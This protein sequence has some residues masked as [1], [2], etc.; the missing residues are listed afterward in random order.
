MR[1]IVF[2]APLS[3]I[4]MN[5]G[6]SFK[7]LIILGV[8]VLAIVLFYRWYRKFKFPRT[9]CISLVTG[10]VKSGKTTFAVGMAIAE[11]KRVHRSWKIRTFFQKI[12][13]KPL[14]EE[15]LLYSNIPLA[16]PYVPVTQ[17]I[18]MRQVRPRY[19]SV[20][21][22]NEASL[23]ADSQTFRDKGINERIMLFN[24]LF[25]HETLGG[26]LYYDTQNLEDLNFEVKRCISEYIYIHHLEKRIPFFLYALV[27][28]E[29]YNYG[30]SGVVNNYGED[31]EESLKKVLIRKKVWKYFDAFC[32]S[33]LT[34]NLPVEDD[35][36]VAEDLK[37]YDIV[38]FRKWESINEKKES[39]NDNNR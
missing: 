8:I 17:K 14:D 9:N 34:D 32:Y 16:V 22:I 13:R 10:G 35:V 5:L 25:G 29:R 1:C 11:Y 20:F 21:L 12:L 23:V 19:N 27:R 30:N 3:Y 37:C 33:A 26:H 24:K 4:K 39:S 2:L 38:S 7:Y 31:L 28:E 15:P 36:C 6:N 18:L